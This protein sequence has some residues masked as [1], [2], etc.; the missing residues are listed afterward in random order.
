MAGPPWVSASPLELLREP[1]SDPTL[2]LTRI[3][4]FHLMILAILVTSKLFY[5]LQVGPRSDSF[6]IESGGCRGF[7]FARSWL[8]QGHPLHPKGS[9]LPLTLG[10]LCV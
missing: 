2:S 7:G 1:Y 8:R 9:S 6:I 3:L 10:D 4:R 5:F